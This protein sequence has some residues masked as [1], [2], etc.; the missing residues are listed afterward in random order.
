M[1]TYNP[2]GVFLV[3]RPR[4]KSR[5]RVKSSVSVGNFAF[6]R[7]V[8]KRTAAPSDSEA[9]Y[10]VD[11]PAILSVV[12]PLNEIVQMPALCPGSPFR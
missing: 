2:A 12:C 7:R 9:L 8:L 10:A 4:R 3:P 5:C 1:K 11:L 6:A